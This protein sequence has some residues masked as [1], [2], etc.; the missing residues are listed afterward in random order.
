LIARSLETTHAQRESVV[1]E[2][3]GDSF[4]GTASK[5]LIVGVVAAW[6][7][8]GGGGG[9]TMEQRLLVDVVIVRRPK[10]RRER[11]AVEQTRIDERL[12]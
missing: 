9:R 3:R 11:F 2:R 1:L 8:D 12:L 7:V 4:L 10:G 5:R 6:L